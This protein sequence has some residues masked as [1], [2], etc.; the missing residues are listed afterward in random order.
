LINAGFHSGG[1][2]ALSA[3]GNLSAVVFFLAYLREQQPCSLMPK[4]WWR[5]RK[6]CTES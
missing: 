4:V 5:S 6:T 1:S 3:L 2:M